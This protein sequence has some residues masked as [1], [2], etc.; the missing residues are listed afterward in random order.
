MPPK[1]NKR[2]R[3]SSPHAAITKKQ[4]QAP[5]LHASSTPDASANSSQQQTSLNLQLVK[6]AFPEADTSKQTLIAPNVKPE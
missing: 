2:K 6:S 4:R 3:A 1:A 5:G